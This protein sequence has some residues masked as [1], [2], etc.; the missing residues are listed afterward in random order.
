MP[1]NIIY[2]LLALSLGLN[3]G[4]IATTV[5]HQTQAPADLPPGPGGGP[6]GGPGSGPGQ[7]PDPERLVNDHLRGMTRHLDLD[8]EQQQAIRA[9]LERSSPELVAMQA[10]VAATARRLSD[11]YAAPDF[12][13][14]QF[15]QLAVAASAARSRLDSLSTVMLIDEAAVLTPEQRKKFAAV[16]PMVHSQPQPPRRERRPPPR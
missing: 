3:V 6:G 11:A 15:R 2:L 5:I 7:A 16:A 4:V 8:A 12:D 1:K 10:E 14:E 13:P 9:V